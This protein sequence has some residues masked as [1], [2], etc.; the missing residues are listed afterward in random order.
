M[1]ASLAGTAKGIVSVCTYCIGTAIVSS[2]ITLINICVQGTT[3]NSNT[4]SEVD[5]YL[6]TDFKC[7]HYRAR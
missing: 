5:A 7:A 2:L 1:V 6:S 3:T 4:V